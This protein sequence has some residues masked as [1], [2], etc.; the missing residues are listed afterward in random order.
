MVKTNDVE[1]IKKEGYEQRFQY[2]EDRNL[3]EDK[4]HVRFFLYY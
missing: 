2:E 4:F 1:K 3:L